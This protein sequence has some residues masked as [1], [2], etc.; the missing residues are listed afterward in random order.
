MITESGSVR[1]RDFLAG[2]HDNPGRKSIVDAMVRGEKI[3][4][5][6][7]SFLQLLLRKGGSSG[8]STTVTKI[9]YEARTEL[10]YKIKI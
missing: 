3:F 5:E 9:A 2:M 1:Y 8:L 6:I 4:L 7:C 10:K